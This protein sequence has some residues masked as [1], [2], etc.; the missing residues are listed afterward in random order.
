MKVVMFDLYDTILKDEAFDFD[1]GLDFLYKSIFYKYCTKDELLTFANSLIPM[2]HNRI[3][4]FEELSF[5]R[6]EIPL[7]FEKFS[8]TTNM[9]LDELDY[10]F[11][12]HTQKV[13]ILDEVIDYLTFLNKNNISMYILSNTIFSTIS[14]KRLL[15][16]FNILHFFKEV[17]CSSEYG[18]RKPSLKFFE[19]GINK[20]L[21]DNPHCNRKNI[22]YIGNDYQTDIKGGINAGLNVIWYNVN[23][24]QNMEQL[25][26][27]DIRSF[28]ELIN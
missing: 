6:K 7:L 22:T 3:I 2:F 28:R 4:T 25:P 23:K 11:M 10:Q 1:L 20:I 18:Y 24:N 19:Y 27:L 17:Y 9:N 26:I 16:D 21:I 13:A 5:I 8:V 12:L 14:T 15:E